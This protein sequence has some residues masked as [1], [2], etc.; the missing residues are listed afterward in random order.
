MYPFAPRAGRWP[1][2]LTLAALAACADEQSDLTAPPV[3]SSTAFA[4][5]DTITVTNTS[6]GTAVGS[7]RWA[8]GQTVGGEV[9]RFAPTIEGATIT[10]DSTLQVPFN[11]TILGPKTKGITISGGGRVRVMQIQRGASLRNLSIT[12]GYDPVI[13]GGIYSDGEL[14][15]QNT[16][17][18][19]NQ[20]P[21][22]GGMYVRS[23]TLLNSTVAQNTAS[24]LASGIS[25]GLPGGLALINST[26]A[27]NKPAPGIRPHGTGDSSFVL[28]RNSIIANN[29]LPL[30]NC[31]NVVHLGYAGANL[32]DDYS[33]LHNEYF[34][35]G[36]P[37]L[38][39]VAD[40]GGPT[41]T[42]AIA[43]QSPALDASLICNVTVDQRYAP[44]DAKCDIGAFEFTDF[45]TV[46]FTTDA[47]ATVRPTNGT[48]VITGTV[49]CSRAGD[50]FSVRVQLN[51][52]QKV[53]NT[54]TVVRG[55]GDT[56]VTCTTAAQPWSVTVTP[57]SSAFIV[58]NAAASAHTYNA[59][60]WVT[61][62]Y[63]D[64]AVRLRK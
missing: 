54:T 52:E 40:N 44:R 45:T 36:D 7:L 42:M 6:G 39:A 37:K 25:Y 18:W 57:W 30:T 43:P 5:Y 14:E 23:A 13:A 28:L 11:I 61:P 17:V 46:T 34:V 8:V 12:G 56:P 26:V 62:A 55:N 49:K 19:N 3:Q 20:A 58:G 24:T 60:K 48:A 2:A 32:S 22:V 64:K 16:T 29:G 10:L 31:Y 4:V 53:G 51:Q 9:I 27:Q 47:N 21:S 35:H 41:P 33:C 50:Q 1:L 59:P 15:L 38:G 63:L